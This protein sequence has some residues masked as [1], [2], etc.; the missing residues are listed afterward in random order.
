M[1]PLES[2]LVL[3][4]RIDVVTPELA[5]AR[6][7]EWAR[8]GQSR[9]VCFADVNLIVRAHADP[10]FAAIINGAALTAPDGMPLVA[11]LRLLGSDATRTCGPD[12]MPLV[13]AA[14]ERE[15]VSVGF[16]GGDEA[17]LARL[18]ARVQAEHPALRVAYVFSPPFRALE[19]EEDARITRDI[20]ASGAQIIFVGLGCPK[21]ERWMA[22][23][24]SRIPAVLLGV[25]AAF[26]FYAGTVQRAPVWIQRIG[27]EWA[28]RLMR[29]PSRLWRRYLLHNPR[30]L[31]LFAKQ[32]LSK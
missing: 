25:G 11:A 2:H 14:A 22:A 1:Q 3:G 32:L 7:L 21:Q 12:V 29:E 18:H 31:V 24:S 27:I 19:D 28:V 16:Y 9:Y 26:D 13:L 8:D 5:V 10:E 30:F 17:T 20:V 6:I 23:H 4:S 15:G